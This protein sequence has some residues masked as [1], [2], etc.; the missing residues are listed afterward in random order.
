MIIC[1]QNKAGLAL[2]SSNALFEWHNENSILKLNGDANWSPSGD[3]MKTLKLK[4]IKF[5][6]S[7]LVLLISLQRAEQSP[8]LWKVN[9]DSSPN[10]LVNGPAVTA[11]TDQ[12]VLN[13]MNPQLSH[14]CAL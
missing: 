10:P 12:S 7:N 6:L 2:N 9:K 14:W 8:T 4:F 11:R 13:S 3:W 5:V 1:L